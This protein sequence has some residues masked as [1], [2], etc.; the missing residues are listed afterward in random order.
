MKNYNEVNPEQYQ[1]RHNANN[2]ERY[3]Y[4]HWSPLVA[5][6][7]HNYCPDKVVVDIGC[8]TGEYTRIAATIAKSVIGF[9]ISPQMIEYARGLSG[10][11]AVADA[12]SIPLAA[13]S[14]Q[15][16]LSIGL[17]EYT[18]PERI[19]SECWRILADRGVLILLCANKYSAIRFPYK[20]MC[21]LTGKEHFAREISYHQMWRLLS[22]FDVLSS[23]M[24]DALIWLPPILDNAIGKPTYEVLDSFVFGNNPLSSVMFFVAQKRRKPAG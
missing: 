13:E 4:G 2:A 14:V 22:G 3:V 19:L 15:V 12:Q 11:Y 21:K 9:D 8:G 24:D 6:A 10:S 7:I 17:L 1:N 20:L 18:I 23:K 5:R 16:V